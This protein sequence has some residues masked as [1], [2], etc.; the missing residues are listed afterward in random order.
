MLYRVFVC[1]A[2][3]PLD[4]AHLPEEVVVHP[5]KSC[6]VDGHASVGKPTQQILVV[7][8]LQVSVGHMGGGR[9]E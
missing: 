9:L 2:L 4:G 6:V 8:G 3:S 1:A 5:Q 7:H